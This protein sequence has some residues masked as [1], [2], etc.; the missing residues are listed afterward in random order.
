MMRTR[1]IHNKSQTAVRYYFTCKFL[2]KE[3][4]S[5][6]S[7]QILKKQNLL[8]YL[9]SSPVRLILLSYKFRKCSLL[10]EGIFLNVRSARLL[11]RFVQPKA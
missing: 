2:S 6:C 5:K 3:L 10:S 9:L 11:E 4:A 1:N 8:V 7:E